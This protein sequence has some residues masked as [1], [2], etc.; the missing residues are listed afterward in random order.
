MKKTFRFLVLINILL[1]AGCLY[2]TWQINNYK[3]FVSKEII[4]NK[5]Q[6]QESTHL[7]ISDV[8]FRDILVEKEMTKEELITI[9]MYTRWAFERHNSFIDLSKNVN[10]ISRDLSE[11][12]ELNNILGRINSSF[13][14]MLNDQSIETIKLNADQLYIMENYFKLLND[15]NAIN[16]EDIELFTQEINDISNNYTELGDY[17]FY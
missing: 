7:L 2:L 13:T 15:I 17:T 10:L 8:D 6:F 9:N 1:L 5:E 11:N 4:E 16:E 14:R 12:M 3:T